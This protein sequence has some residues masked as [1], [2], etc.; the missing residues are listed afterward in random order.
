MIF[1]FTGYMKMTLR[2]HRLLFN[3]KVQLPYLFL[4]NVILKGNFAFIV[5]PGLNCGINCFCFL[6]LCA[7][8]TSSPFVWEGDS[9]VTI[10]SCLGFLAF[11]FCSNGAS[12]W[13]FNSWNF[14]LPFSH[15]AKLEKSRNNSRLNSLSCSIWYTP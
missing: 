10:V 13:K 2:S 4:A 7:T 1:I 15:S 8:E 3:C 5:W 9:G 14:Q 11:F 12:S 6:S